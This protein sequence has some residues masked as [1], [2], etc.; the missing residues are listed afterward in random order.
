MEAPH[1]ILEAFESL[2]KYEGNNL[3]LRKIKNGFY[4]YRET[5]AWIKELKHSRPKFEYLGS[6]T[7][8]GV[9]K[10]KRITDLE[11]AKLV[12]QSH[13]GTVSLPEPPESRPTAISLSA[14]DVDRT[15]LT[16]LSM[17]GRAS[18]KLICRITN[19]PKATVYSRIK[20]LEDDYGIRYFADID[21]EKLGYFRYLIFIK[22]SGDIPDAEE[23]KDIVKDEPHI[24][25]AA[26]TSGKYDLVMHVLSESQRDMAYFLHRLRVETQLNKYPSLWYTTPYYSRMHIFPLRKEFFKLLKEKVWKRTPKKPRPEYGDLTEREYNVL[27]ELNEDGSKN[28][29][30]IDK[31]Y[32]YGNG[33]T[34]YTYLKLKERGILSY[35][36]VTLEKL[37]IKYTAMLFLEH[38][39]MDK[40]RKTRQNLLMEAIKDTKLT[41]KYALTGNID[42]PHSYLLAMPVFNEDDLISTEEYIKKNIGGIRLSKIII[43]KNI[44]GS[45][46]Y[47]RL[48]NTYTNQYKLLVEEYKMIKPSRQLSYEEKE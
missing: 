25:F 35:I 8:D 23:I 28:F 40:F 45:L 9:F 48:D 5:G 39:E 21:T 4:V 36:T 1:R 6:I 3:I 13:G 38:I 33:T 31:K 11:T 10:R 14:E 24:Q 27:L 30:D 7:Q 12:I 15:I 29:I 2:R 16:I 44:V 46:C 22:L 34:R 32:G 37:P 43:I 41:N 47:R 17:N 19:L 42:T 18:I 26:L 20:R